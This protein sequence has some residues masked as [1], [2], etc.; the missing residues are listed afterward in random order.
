MYSYNG[1]QKRV[2]SPSEKISLGFTLAEVLIT[3]AIIGIVAA[4]TIPSFFSRTNNK[5][6]VT[7]LQKAYST[8]SQVSQLLAADS[9]GSLEDA[10]TSNVSNRYDHNGFANL[11]AKKMKVSIVCGIASAKATGCAPT[12]NYLDLSGNTT[13]LDNVSS[14]STFSQFLSSDG[15]TYSFGL[16][17]DN[18]NGLACNWNM[19][20]GTNALNNMCGL[21]YVD[22]NG[23]NKGPRTVGRDLF[24]FAATKTGIVPMGI[25]T[26]SWSNQ[27]NCTTGSTSYYSGGGCAGKVISEGAM[28]Y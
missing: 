12:Q 2:K 18:T 11:F 25:Y 15:M 14:A 22:I 16:N 4:I 17:L 28:N 8:L 9:G 24:M 23:P 7:G 19:S 26:D 27:L 10:I 3:L 13:K 5:E 21:I 6:L 1:I 20:T